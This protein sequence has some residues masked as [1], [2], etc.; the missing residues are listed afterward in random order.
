MIKTRIIYA[1]MGAYLILQTHSTLADHPTI[2][3]G[4]EGIGAIN[5]I[6]ASPLP[7][8]SWAFGV[9][10]EI[11]N[12]KAFTNEQLEDFA[13]DGLE[14]VHSIDKIT[15]TSIALAYGATEDFTI[16]AR[17]P[18]IERKNI[19]EGELEAGIPEAHTH[20]DSSG[21]GDLLLFG[22]YRFQKNNRLDISILFGI[23]APTGET[24]KR[25]N[26]G[27]LFETEFQPGTGAWDFLLGAAVSKSNGTLG[28]HANILYNKTTE[29]EQSTEIG[30]VLSYNAAITYQLG[31]NHANH[32]HSQDG[33]TFSEGARWDLS[34]ELN[35]ETRAKNKIAGESEENS[36][37][38]LIYLSP[39]IRVSSGNFSGFI[40]YGV[41]IVEDQN[42]KQTDVNSRIIAGFSVAL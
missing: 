8:D 31:H 20:G 27:I 5:T 19:R 9:R 28:Y 42:G 7:A 24:D 38:T 15:N 41:P 17:L 23:K 30:D 10:S 21:V 16:S 29:G 37:G 40:S 3:F 6:S 2:A 26:D 33:A 34:V 32:D 4:N 39:G 11:I 36:G 22:Q 1:A 12:N 25:D 35:G 18:Y 13:A 14:G